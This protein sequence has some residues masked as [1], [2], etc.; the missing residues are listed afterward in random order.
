MKDTSV[1]VLPGRALFSPPKRKGMLG[2][3]R[4]SGHLSLGGNARR[5]GE[6]AAS[7]A[8]ESPDGAPVAFSRVLGD[9][10]AGADRTV[11]ERAAAERARRAA[12]EAER[13][14]R[15]GGDEMTA[16]FLYD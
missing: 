13:L 16:R 9:L 14:A 7:P 5:A 3:L 15:A 10:W 8:Q 2:T 4:R 12:A 6:R 11:A 1:S